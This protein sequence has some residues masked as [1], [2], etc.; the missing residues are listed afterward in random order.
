MA[1]IV[2]TGACPIG[3][4]LRVFVTFPD[5]WD[6]VNLDTADHRSHMSYANGALLEGELA[7]PADHPYKIPEVAIQAFFTV[8]ANFEAGKWHLASDEM[9]PGTVA[10]TTLHMDYWEAWSSI[11]KNLWQTYCID[12]H[13]T[14]SAGDLGNGQ[15]VNGMQQVGSFP[16][17]PKVPLS[18]IQ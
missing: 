6:G 7:C 9:V 12:G 3:A 16:V 1:D 18:T 2:A 8:D 5:C 10:G 13:L 15:Q 4:W 14:C 17:Q 11:V